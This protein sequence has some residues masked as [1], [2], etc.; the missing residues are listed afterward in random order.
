MNINY[1]YFLQKARLVSQLYSNAKILDY[2]CGKGEIVVAGRKEG[3]NIY[4]TDKFYDGDPSYEEVKTNQNNVI[5]KLESNNKIPFP[6]RTFDLVISNQVIEHIDDLETALS[7]IYRVMKLDG[8]FIS[9]FPI[10]E[11]VYEG[12]IGI[13]F[14]HWFFPKSKLRYYYTF[15]ARSINF[16]YNKA[17]KSNLQWTKD[18]L[19]WIDRYTY[20]RKKSEIFEIFEKYFEIDTKEIEIDYLQYR[21]SQLP[22]DGHKN[23]SNLLSIPLIANCLRYLLHKGS[24]IVISA[25]KTKSLLTEK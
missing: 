10:Y 4:G 9:R 11:T 15:L 2:G 18:S 14:A 21:I 17:D 12:H 20:Y 24:G 5:F 25:K 13:P 22:I 23:I 6:N 7:E 1:C 3:I 8:I 16:G 19:K